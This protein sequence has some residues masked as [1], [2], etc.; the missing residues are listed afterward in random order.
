MPVPIM[1][2]TTMH[3]AVNGEM[4]LPRQVWNPN[5]PGDDLGGAPRGVNADC[6]FPGVDGDRYL[7]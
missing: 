7:G 5:S 1:F 6:N 2:A 3:V 4:F